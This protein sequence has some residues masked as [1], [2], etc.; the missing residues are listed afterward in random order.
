MV[1]RLG[2]GAGRAV[3]LASGTREVKE[4]MRHP[5]GDIQLVA[6][7]V[8]MMVGEKR[9]LEIQIGSVYFVD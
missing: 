6:G 9:E 8:N 4:A 7:Q 2:R 1:S 3:D 5:G